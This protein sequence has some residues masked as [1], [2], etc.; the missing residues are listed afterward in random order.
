MNFTQGGD[1]SVSRKSAGH[2]FLAFYA[3]G[4][5]V[6]TGRSHQLYDLPAIKTFE[7][8]VIAR[9]GLE[10]RGDDAFGP[11]WNPPLFAWVFAPLSRLS[12]SAAWLVWTGAN[13]LCL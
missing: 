12:Y 7:R 1:R 6:R 8:E 5:F 4:T 9:E 11:Y 10:L 2:D 13:L 3:A